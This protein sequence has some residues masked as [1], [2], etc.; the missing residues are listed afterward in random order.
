MLCLRNPDHLFDRE[1]DITFCPENRP[2][3]SH[4]FGAYLTPEERKNINRKGVNSG[5]M[6]MRT[7]NYLEIMR[8]WERI[9]T[10][11]CSPGGS[12]HE[13]GAWNRLILDTK[14]KTRPFERDA[15]M[16]PMNEELDYRVYRDATLVHCLGADVRTKVRFMY[17][18]YMSTF[19]F[20]DSLTLLNILDM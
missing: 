11:P 5:T 13:Q 14:L 8:E 7:E 4:I 3:T 12:F 19:F 2:I 16:F 6:A 9:H 1:E 17:G 20:D 10:G 18:L 15:I